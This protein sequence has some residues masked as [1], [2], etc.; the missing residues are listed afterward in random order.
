MIVPPTPGDSE[1]SRSP[2]DEFLT[3]EVN[4]YIRVQLLTAIEQMQAGIRYFTYNAFNVLLD[5]DA[6]TAIVEDEFNIHAGD[7]RCLLVGGG[8]CIACGTRGNPRESRPGRGC[9][10]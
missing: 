1:M 3:G 10:V 9:G 2:I 6:S 7:C 8:F 4:G 5:A